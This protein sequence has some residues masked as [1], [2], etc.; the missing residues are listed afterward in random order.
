MQAGDAAQWRRGLVLHG[1]FAASKLQGVCARKPKSRRIA[2]QYGSHSG[3]SQTGDRNAMRGGARVRVGGREAWAA[4]RVRSRAGCRHGLIATG[5][6]GAGYLP[7]VELRRGRLCWA[8]LVV[9]GLSAVQAPARLERTCR[10]RAG[11]PRKC[12][13]GCPR[14][15]PWH[16]QG[17]G[18]SCP[19]R[20][21]LPEQPAPRRARCASDFGPK[22]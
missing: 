18:A 6:L 12:F 19:A 20:T 13:R 15:C 22:R 8:R 1:L 10:G 9:G 5:Q 17:I 14:R 3:G 21:F 16:T 2:C 11:S 4:A 7:G